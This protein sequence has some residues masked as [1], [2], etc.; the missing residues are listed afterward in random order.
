MINSTIAYKVF[1]FSACVCVLQNGNWELAECEKMYPTVCRT[2]GLVPLHPTGEWDEGCPEVD[3]KQ[4]CLTYRMTPYSTHSFVLHSKS[5][6]DHTVV[7]YT[8]MKNIEWRQKLIQA[9]I[10]LYTPG[11]EKK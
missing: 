10:S 7:L 6:T 1:F 11:S 9:P 3:E 5:Y 4:L 2:T 8:F